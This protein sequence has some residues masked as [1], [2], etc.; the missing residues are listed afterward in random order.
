MANK[1]FISHKNTDAALATKVA[2]RIQANGLETYLDT[3]D[4]A[5][6]KD[7]PELADLLL[8][9]MSS[10]QQLIA[11]V[12]SQTKDSWWV[13]WE[14]GV[15]SEKGFRMASYSESYISLPS[16]LEKWPALHTDG[17]IDL[18]CQYSKQTE[19]VVNRRIREAL[20]EERRMQVRKSEALDFHKQLKAAIR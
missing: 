13:P 18:Y 15:G 14:I 1:V 2:R 4:D 7:G 20:T 19:V 5:L 6:V 12:S 10:C 8:A 9:R 11:V 16:Y 3:I 17:H